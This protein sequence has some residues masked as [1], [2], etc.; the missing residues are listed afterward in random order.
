[1]EK[2]V[3]KRSIQSVKTSLAI[4]QLYCCGVYSLWLMTESHI[5]LSI[6]QYLYISI[7]MFPGILI[8]LIF[9]SY[10]IFAQIRKK[11]TMGMLIVGYGQITARTF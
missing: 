11:Q 3:K 9:L 10:Q 6:Y 1:M 8:R 7:P 2:K 4:M 5:K